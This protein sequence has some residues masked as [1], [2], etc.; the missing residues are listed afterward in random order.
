MST[1]STVLT[2]VLKLASDEQMRLVS[3]L[4][5]RSTILSPKR[6]ILELSGLGKEILHEIDAGEYVNQERDS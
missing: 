6:S 1:Y 4:F 5:A 2:Q 3:E